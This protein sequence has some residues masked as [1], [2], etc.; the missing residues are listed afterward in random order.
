MMKVKRLIV[1][2]LEGACV[3][4]RHRWCHRFALWSHDLDQR[5]GTEE[6]HAVTDVDQFMDEVFK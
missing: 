3:L 1:K 4:T 5:W 6:W 2:S